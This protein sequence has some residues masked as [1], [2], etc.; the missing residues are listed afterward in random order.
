[1]QGTP[2]AAMAALLLL[3]V[4]TSTAASPETHPSGA[5]PAA[6]VSHTSGKSEY[7]AWTLEEARTNAHD[8]ANRLDKMTPAEWD[9]IQK[10]RGAA[11]KQW[12][13][14]NKKAFNGTEHRP[15]HP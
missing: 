14:R 8:Y 11:L 12:R 13:D 6:G 2:L 10:K 4:Q 7:H 5:V 3:S 1:M 15:G 9:S